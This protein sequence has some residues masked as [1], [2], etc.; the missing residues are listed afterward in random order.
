ML[1][2][3]HVTDLAVKPIF[4]DVHSMKIVPYPTIFLLQVRKPV[5]ALCV[6]LEGF[7]LLYSVYQL[8]DQHSRCDFQR[9]HALGLSLKQHVS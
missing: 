8:L 7:Q 3:L 2:Y 5:K 6:V 1:H 9:V 4:V